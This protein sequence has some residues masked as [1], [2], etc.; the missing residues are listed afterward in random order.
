MA[1]FDFGSIMKSVVPGL[2]AAASIYSL[3]QKNNEVGSAEELGGVLSEEDIAKLL[4]SQESK[5][6]GRAISDVKSVRQA[7]AQ[8]GAF[9]SG[10]LPGL[11]LQARSKV[12]EGLSDLE[13]QLRMRNAQARGVG[14]RTRAGILA[15]QDTSRQQAAGSSLGF[16]LSNLFGGE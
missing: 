3:F 5:L 14:A 13:N 1:K 16:N 7:A 15:G 11:E 9:R 4:S 12:G 8:R 10:Q 2:G 6:Q